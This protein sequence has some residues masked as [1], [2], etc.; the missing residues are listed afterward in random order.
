MYF[1]KK[2]AVFSNENTVR[3]RFPSFSQQKYDFFLILWKEAYFGPNLWVQWYSSE[4]FSMCFDEKMAVLYDK[5]MIFAII[6]TKIWF[7][8]IVWR[9]A[10][11]RPN[12]WINWYS[13]EHFSMCFD[14]KMGVCSD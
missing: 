11:F 12:L 9:I 3:G 10:Y 5:N 7:S 8:L 14:E 13:N 2:M 1:D 6:S 4:H